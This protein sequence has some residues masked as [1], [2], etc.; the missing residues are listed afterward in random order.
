MRT[1]IDARHLCNENL[2]NEKISHHNREQKTRNNKGPNVKSAIYS[3]VVSHRRFSPQKHG[4]QYRVFMVY[5]NL[6][7]IDEFLSLSRWWSRS[8]WGIARFRREDFHGDPDIDLDESVRRTIEERVG[9]RPLGDIC[10]LANFRYFGFNMNPIVTYYCFDK[11]GDSLQYIVAEVN[12]TPWNE[13][14]AYVIPCGSHVE[15]N[16][17]G[18]CD[19]NNVRQDAVFD[20]AFTVSP[21]NHLDMTY[22][23][24]STTPGDRLALHIDSLQ[25]NEKITDATLR[26]HREE[27]TNASLSRILVRFPFMTVKVM[28][29]I[30]WQALRLALKG[31]PFLGKNKRS[32]QKKQLELNQYEVH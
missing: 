15:S 12:N 17:E 31:V 18:N 5:L 7:E 28:S 8:R 13:K 14:H 3:G 26:L 11:T 22:R 29:A 27:A 20:K 32:K 30:Y 16:G 25:G 1:Q 6:G 19:G 10:M 24:A 4:F 23:W 2:S 21:F 9:E